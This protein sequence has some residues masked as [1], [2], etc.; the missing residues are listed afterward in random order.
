M[1]C[2]LC[3]LE[4]QNLTA[5]TLILLERNPFQISETNNS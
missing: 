1:S 3:T 4:G 5:I 2:F